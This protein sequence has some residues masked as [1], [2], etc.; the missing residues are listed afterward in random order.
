MQWRESETGSSEKKH[1]GAHAHSYTSCDDLPSRPTFAAIA[2]IATNMTSGGGMPNAAFAMHEASALVLVPS[3]CF[4]G[5][6]RS[7]PRSAAES[8]ALSDRF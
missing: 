7:G 6:R 8:A 2:E 1:R 5:I 3:P 4:G